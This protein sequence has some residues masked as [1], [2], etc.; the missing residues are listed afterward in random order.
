MARPRLPSDCSF[1]GEN[2]RS[3]GALGDARPGQSSLSA[4]ALRPLF[5][6]WGDSFWSSSLLLTRR[7][8]IE[9]EDVT[10]TPRDL[11]LE[12]DENCVCVRFTGPQNV[13]FRAQS[14]VCFSFQETWDYES[15]LLLAVGVTHATRIAGAPRSLPWRPSS[16]SPPR[17][18]SLMA[19]S[20]PPSFALWRK[21]HWL[22]QWG[23]K[24]P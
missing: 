13:L 22:S 19:E 4:G 15:E 3:W 11:N 7:H 21:Y 12:N 8:I 6:L 14:V 10:P 23:Q 9:K 5:H 24:P 20:S 18:E 17:V 1:P 16:A 2:A